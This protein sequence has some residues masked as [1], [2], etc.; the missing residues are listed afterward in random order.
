[1]CSW[2]NVDACSS[3]A[4]YSAAADMSP[5]MCTQAVVNCKGNC[6]DVWGRA[7]YS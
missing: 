3:I 6:K 5:D 2:Q 1:M 4:C 7:I